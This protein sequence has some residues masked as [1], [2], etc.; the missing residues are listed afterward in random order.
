MDAHTSIR[1]FL[2]DHKIHDYSLQGRG[3]REH[4]KHFNAVLLTDDISVDIEAHFYKPKAKP[5][6]DGDPRIWFSLLHKHVEADNIIA[7]GFINSEEISNRIRLSNQ[8]CVINISRTNLASIL[9]SK[10]SCPIR[11]YLNF[12]QI[13]SNAIANEL[14]NKLRVIASSGPLQSVMSTYADTAIGRTI[15]HALGI[16]MNPNRAPDYK[17]IELKSSRLRKNKNR[18]NL[19]G[20]I[21]DWSISKMNS[22]KDILDAFGYMSTVNGD[23]RKRLNVTVSTTNTNPQGLYLD[24]DQRNDLL[25][26]CST[27]NHYGAFASWRLSYLHSRLHTKHNETFWI[28]ANTSFDQNG[29]ELFHLTD[30][31]HTRRPLTSQ[32]DLL[33]S[34]GDITLDHGMKLLDSGVVKERGPF[35]KMKKSVRGLLLPN[36]QKYTI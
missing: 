19:F 35:F 36:P 24:V 28:S 30:V 26:E 6:Q 5:S 17:G 2:L 12:A 32:F 22:M 13:N 8:I 33:L 25:N 18:D 4:G 23:H 16:P 20:Q 1:K 34:Q 11:D 15:E 31:E 14:L 29:K 9:S 27:N 21:P 7:I 10:K 3:A